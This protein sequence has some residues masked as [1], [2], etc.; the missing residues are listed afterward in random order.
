MVYAPVPQLLVVAAFSRHAAALEWARA[1]LE[2]EWGPIALASD[3]FV[4]DQ[5]RYYET[6]MGPELRKLFY[7]FGDLVPPDRLA[8]IKV[9]TN[10][11]EQELSASGK[12]AESRPLNLDPGMLGLGKFVLATTKDQAHRIYLRD[13]IYAEVTLRFQD[14]RFQTWPWTY[15]DYQ[16][17]EV[18]EFFG[19]AREFYK[20]RRS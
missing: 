12:F 13:D 10:E 7:V 2:T 6:S 14:G 18:L 5:T 11:L 17:P 4:F 8:A 1:R 19:Q 15:A 9:R 20:Q 3:P 16:Q